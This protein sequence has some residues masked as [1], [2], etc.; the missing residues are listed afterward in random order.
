MAA[1][2]LL[3]PTIAAVSAACRKE[4]T[5]E[6]MLLALA[7]RAVPRPSVC[8]FGYLPVCLPACSTEEARGCHSTPAAAANGDSLQ[9]LLV[10]LA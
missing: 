3:A 5:N 9:D 10:Q 2:R 8:V 1:T 4:P 7:G 6:P